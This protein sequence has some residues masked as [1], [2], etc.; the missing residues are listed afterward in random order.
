MKTK[1]AWLQF[2]HE[3]T[4]WV[5]RL[6]DEP[7]LPEV[8]SEVEEW[9]RS[10]LKSGGALNMTSKAGYSRSWLV[11]ATELVGKKRAHE[12]LVEEIMK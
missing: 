1:G 10:W 12:I 8:E 9:L 6:A 7:L 4:T 5:E 11:R 3:Y 2:N